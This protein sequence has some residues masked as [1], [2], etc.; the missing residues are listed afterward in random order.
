MADVKDI[1][2]KIAAGLPKADVRVMDPMNDGQHLEAIVVAAEFEGKN[3]VARHRI[4]Y[5]ALG[6]AFKAELHALALAT[7]TPQ[8]FKE[9]E[10]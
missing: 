3:Q 2:T 4:V 6:D 7:F 8:E 1:Q 9:R 10:K 5:A